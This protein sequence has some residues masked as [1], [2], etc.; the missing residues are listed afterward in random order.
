MIEIELM[1]RG[2]FAQPRVWAERR[3]EAVREFPAG[4]V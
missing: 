4:F 2:L 3:R 1:G